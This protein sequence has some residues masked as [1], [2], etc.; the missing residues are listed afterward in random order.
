MHEPEQC[1]LLDITFQLLRLFPEMQ[2][3]NPHQ[4][5]GLVPIDNSNS[6]SWQGIVKVTLKE[7]RC[8]WVFKSYKPELV[9][10][11]AAVPIGSCFKKLNTTIL[12]RFKTNQSDDYIAS[13]SAAGRH[14]WVS[15]ARDMHWT[16]S[17]GSSRH[18]MSQETVA[19]RFL[20]SLPGTEAVSGGRVG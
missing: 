9:P 12:N 11:S 8:F 16:T 1:V 19:G 3:Q 20:S 17:E 2:V 15:T 13:P 7:C 5:K 18:R 14:M 6:T 4:T 10:E